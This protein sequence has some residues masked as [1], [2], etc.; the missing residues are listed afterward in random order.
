MTK[1]GG[2]VRIIMRTVRTIMTKWM[3]RAPQIQ[4][5]MKCLFFCGSFDAFH[6]YMPRMQYTP[7]I[8]LKSHAEGPS[9]LK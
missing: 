2:T 3:K 5:P 9:I 1:P 6:M 8:M 4:K 7:R